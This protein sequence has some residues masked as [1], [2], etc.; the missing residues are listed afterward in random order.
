MYE[1]QAKNSDGQAKIKH[2]V[3][4]NSNEQFVHARRIEHAERFK[5]NVV[6]DSALSL[7]SEVLAQSAQLV[8]S[9]SV[10]KQ[11]SFSDV[12]ENLIQVEITNEEQDI[13]EADELPKPIKA[14]T[15]QPRAMPRRHFDEGPIEP[16]I[17]RDSKKKL[18]WE[19]KLKS[20]TASE[21]K[22][23]K[24]VCIVTGPQPQ[25]KWQKNGKPLVWSKNVVNKTKGEFGSVIIKNATLED[26]GEYT[27]QA[28]NA[29][30]EIECSGRVTVFATAKQVETVPT[31]TRVTGLYFWF[32]KF[33]NSTF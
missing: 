33:P 13:K 12:P 24:I 8:I 2:E 22:D 25:F 32:C 10:D 28:K 15:P 5:R 11:E 16:F 27:A 7:S 31:F 18:T 20:I 23:I 17:I 3:K 26:S 21:G 29:D 30:S 19:A 1:C 4:F 14:A 9:T 6:D